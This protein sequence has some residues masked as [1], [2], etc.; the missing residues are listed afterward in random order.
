MEQMNQQEISGGQ[1]EKKIK[2]SESQKAAVLFEGE[3]LLVSAAAGSGKTAVL[4]ERIMELLMGRPDENKRATKEPARIDEF[5]IV[6]FTNAAA[7]QMREKIAGRIDQLL[8]SE[9]LSEELRTHLEQQAVLVHYAQISTIHSFCM[10]VIR[11]NFTLINLDP[12]FRMGDEIQM[13]LLAS[14]CME[15]VIE[16]AYANAKNKEDG[17]YDFVECFCTGKHDHRLADMLLGIYRG[18]ISNPCPEEWM[19]QMVEGESVSGMLTTLFEQTKETL[20]AYLEILQLAKATCLEPGGP[21]A[22][23]TALDSDLVSVSELLDLLR[24]S[25]QGVSQQEVYE[26][27]TSRLSGLSFQ[28]L[29]RISKKVPVDEEKKEN[30]KKLREEVKTGLGKLK[31]NEF[32]RTFQEIEEEE[33]FMKQMFQQMRRLVLSFMEEFRKEKEEQ[34][35]L[36]FNDL[37][38]MA[39]KIL[40][41]PVEGDGRI[42]FEP[43][44]AAKEY[45]EHFHEIMIDEYQD[46]NEIQEVI[47]GSVSKKN[48]FMVGDVKQSIYKFRMA[49]PE[50]FEMKH[51]SYQKV[52]SCTEFPDSGDCLIELSNNYR[53][54]DRVLD[55]INLIFEGIMEKAV[56]NVDYD[57]DARLYY[58]DRVFEEY[59]NGQKTKTECLL[60]EYVQGDDPKEMEAHLVAKR[61]R[62]MLD[63]GELI[64][65]DEIKEFRQVKKG[66]IVILFR[67]MSGWAETFIK[68]LAQ[69]GIEAYSDTQS[70]FFQ[71]DEVKTMLHLLRVLD[72][73]RQDIPL[74]AIMMS[75]VFC[76]SEE[77]LSYIRENCRDTGWYHAVQEYLQSG[78]N[79]ALVQKIKDMDEKIACWRTKK[80]QLRISELLDY[81]MEESG[82]LD[83]MTVLPGGELRRANLKLLVEKAFAFESTKDAGI[84]TFLRYI[85][86]LIHYEVD[87]GEAEAGKNRLDSVTVMSIHKSKGLEFPV[88]FVAG[89]NK[90][91]NCMDQNA[92]LLVH[93]EYGV[94]TDRMDHHRRIKK[95]T[96]RKELLQNKMSSE[97]KGEEIRI[98]YV[99]MT[100]AK[101]KLFLTGCLSDPESAKER[102]RNQAKQMKRYEKGE[103]VR[104][105]LSAYAREKAGCYL[106]YVMPVL[107]FAEKEQSDQMESLFYV[108]YILR[109]EL[110]EEEI[111]EQ[112]EEQK[113]DVTIEKLLNN[114]IT[115]TDTEKE[116]IQP[117]FNYEYPY[118]VLAE[119]KGK[120]S[121]S[122]LK[123]EAY[124]KALQEEQT[125]EQKAE[126]E[127][128]TAEAKV[129][130]LPEGGYDTDG[131]YHVDSGYGS[132]SD[133][134][135][136]A[137]SDIP[138]PA[139][140]KET[141]ELTGADL[142]TL[143]HFVM[144]KVDYRAVESSSEGIRQFLEELE[145]KGLI[146]EKE[147]K[148]LSVTKIKKFIDSSLGKRMKAA[149]VQGK[150]YR[151][152][153]FVMGKPAC[154]VYKDTRSEET[155]LIQGIIDAYFEE[156]GEIVL[157]DYKTDHVKNAEELIK[158]YRTQ[159][160]L[161]REALERGTNKRVKQVILYSFHHG[162]EVEVFG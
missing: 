35:I 32:G 108:E 63:E 77:E 150:L 80:N 146:T 52:T 158:R 89:M 24:L 103:E 154:D 6:T 101:E 42:H 140:R 104:W 117:Y 18:A 45:R 149:A 81:L 155:I 153:P 27:V 87:F 68:I 94:A 123:K 162:K 88:V 82:Y 56:G 30:V 60:G 92:A 156:D 69:E 57:K 128:D 84:F 95:R 2:L 20:D 134:V 10:R 73:P 110:M 28:T 141:V 47:L 111:K 4:V 91:F 127:T 53:S 126:E 70:G 23:L 102:W 112:Q 151:E 9:V 147:R 131:V 132:G 58:K 122:E 72:N 144:E 107:C 55:S 160:E 8:E 90:G 41:N 143:Y 29:G 51:R 21:E 59:P 97:M 14:D 138:E 7:A 62:K 106:D 38:H 49:K 54:R 98:L 31:K 109:H 133:G 136:D 148:K 121:V 78:K 137:E 3:N 66:D 125:K 135:H 22:Y 159:M 119:K 113:A 26:Q 33:Q 145:G 76:F 83:Q 15:K 93:S 61:I 19:D 100:R 43:S 67:A 139:F 74:A 161:Y 1:E 36:D 116:K 114:K 5:L 17:F 79:P 11:E 64:Y 34:R 65:D 118:D 40:T 129:M 39:L 105:I 46:S 16:Q 152:K 13:K 115:L 157:V 12:S 86:K 37:E 99:A 25:E 130:V 124:E 44:E 96:L 142:G 75:P 85:E 48:L 50:L 120:V 71:T